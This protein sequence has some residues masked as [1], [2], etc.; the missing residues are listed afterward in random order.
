MEEQNAPARFIVL[1]HYAGKD[2]QVTRMTVE[3]R[4]YADALACIAPGADCYKVEII[5]I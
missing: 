1:M 4:S 3:A 2:G 5:A